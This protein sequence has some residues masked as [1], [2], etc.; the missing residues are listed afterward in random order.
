MQE[1]L[2]QA[3]A[4]L[5]D[6]VMGVHGPR[7]VQRLVL[8]SV[9]EKVLRLGTCPVLTVR[10]GVRVARRASRLAER[11][12][13]PRPSGGSEQSRGVCQA[14]SAGGRRARSSRC[15]A[16]EWPF[17]DA[18]TSGV[19][20]ASKELSRRARATGRFV[21]CRVRVL[22]GQARS[23]CAATGKASAAIVKIARARSVGISS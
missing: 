16:V 7:S 3:K 21:C 20:A 13:V 9:A 4:S 8:G 1:V 17:G 15:N 14:T 11:S 10:R 12:S 19:V 5:A 2:A 22:M 18:V 6:L 23:R